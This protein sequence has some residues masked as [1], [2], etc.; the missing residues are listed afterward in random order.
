MKIDNILN[1]S[2]EWRRVD[3]DIPAQGKVPAGTGKAFSSQVLNINPDGMCFLAPEGTLAGQDVS[4]SMDLPA[5]GK[6]EV[7]LKVV[8]AGYFDQSKS[9]RAGGKFEALPE[10]EK[11]KFLRFYHLKIMSLL[12]G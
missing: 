9:Y 6:L 2:R 3:V 8:W 11:A 7:R 12:G 1:E 10:R 5:I 4:L